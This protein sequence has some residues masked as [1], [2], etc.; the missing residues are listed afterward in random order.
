MPMN[1]YIIFLVNISHRINYCVLVFIGSFILY[2]ILKE[3]FTLYPDLATTILLFHQE[4]NFTDKWMVISTIL[5]LFILA[6]LCSIAYC[7]YKTWKLPRITK[8]E[9][10]NYIRI[11]RREKE[12]ASKSE[13]LAYT[14]MKIIREKLNFDDSLN[15]SLFVDDSANNKSSNM[16]NAYT[17]GMETIL[18]GTH[19]ICLNS[20]L[21]EKI[22]NTNVAAVVAHEMGHVKNQDTAT[23]MFMG[24]FRAF[25]SFVLFAPLYILYAILMV[26]SWMFSAIPLLDMFAKLFLFISG[27]I[28]GCVRFLELLVMWPAYLYERYVSNRTEYLADAVAANCIGPLSICRVLYILSK[29][30]PPPN[31]NRLLSFLEKL[32]I[33]N[34]THPSFKNRIRAI[35][36]RIYTEEA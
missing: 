9:D 24:C 4:R 20:K 26:L 12:T 19:A 17:L 6:E 36:K 28:I 13:A 22:P 35:Q 29:R 30:F 23:K 2:W 16:V 8:N 34:S 15:T 25:V 14:H 3:V 31:N 7:M 18:G 11:R 10:G 5:A 32:Q 21:L 33:S 27:L 1:T